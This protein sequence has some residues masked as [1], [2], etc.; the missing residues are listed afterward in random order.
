MTPI[1]LTLLMLAAFL[2]GSMAMLAALLLAE[3]RIRR[4]YGL[5]TERQIDDALVAYRE[6]HGVTA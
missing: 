1:T 5:H 4:K 3:R 6:A 2:T